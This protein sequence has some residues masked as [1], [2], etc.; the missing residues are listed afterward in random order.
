[1]KTPSS[2]QKRKLQCICGSTFRQAYNTK[3]CSECNTLQHPECIGSLLKMKRYVCPQCQLKQIDP[4]LKHRLNFHISL[5]K[6]TENKSESTHEFRFFLNKD[7]LT[8]VTS[9]SFLIIRSLLLN[10]KGFKLE[11]TNYFRLELNK[12][13]I[14]YALNSK[15]WL[16]KSH[17][18][19]F[20]FAFNETYKDNINKT[21]EKHFPYDKQI[22]SFKEYFNIGL[23][24][25]KMIIRYDKEDPD[26][27]SYA[28]SVD[29]VEL[30]QNI[31][32]VIKYLPRVHTISESQRYIQFED[33]VD[34]EKINL[35]DHYTLCERIVLPGRGVAC[36][37]LGVFDVKRFLIGN[38][39]I[40]KYTCPIC[41]KYANKC[42]ID[43]IMKN[44]I[45]KEEVRNCNCLVMDYNYNVHIKGEDNKELFVN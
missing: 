18:S 13:K 36:N 32:A 3:P 21:N 34:K 28:L 45:E 15:K 43:E 25:I 6:T 1:M 39:H 29:L 33:G 9:N 4:F 42:Y 38:I 40:R 31:D 30:F 11:W 35:Y 41:M 44:V 16:T 26:I 8:K 19:P 2:P 10:E 37:H 23:N 14:T 5:I 22:F 12:K 17:N 7:Q 27:N 20:V 24:L